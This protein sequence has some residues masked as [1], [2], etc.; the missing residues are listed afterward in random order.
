MN[1]K[2]KLYAGLDE[3]LPNDATN[4]AIILDTDIDIS[5]DDVIDRFNIPRE[6]AHLILLNGVFVEPSARNQHGLF[7]DGDTLAIWPP[8]AGG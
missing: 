6:R 5:V 8:V 1:L 7:K 3:Y 4:N 2:I